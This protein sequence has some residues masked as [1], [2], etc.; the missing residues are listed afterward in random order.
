MAFRDRTPRPGGPNKARPSGEIALA[1]GRGELYLVPVVSPTAIPIIDPP[2]RKGDRARLLVTASSIEGALGAGQEPEVLGVTPRR[3]GSRPRKR[4]RVSRVADP[5]AKITLL[6]AAEEVFSERGVAGAKVE[7]IAKKAGL[8]KGAFYLHFDSKE[9]AL[10]QIVESWLAR[11][12]S[13]FAA[14]NEY[15]DAPDDPDMLLDFCIEREVQLY[16]FLWQ[17][18][19]TMRILRTCQGE[20]D[21]LIDAFKTDMQ[22]RSREWL[23]Q[24]RRDGLIRPEIDVEIA[25]TLMSGAYEEL[26]ARMVRSSQRPPFEKW[27]ELAQETF[28]RAY[29]T[30]E[31]VL[32][33][34]RRNRRVTTGVHELRRG[35][36]SDAGGRSVRVAREG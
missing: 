36:S 15:P 2:V 7:D 10:K 32:A 21:Y 22:R 14:P 20:Y 9:A 11:C 29:G 34:E 13:L 31:L 35:V 5:K 25:A 26:A 23:D 28:V 19:A 8:S 1:L 3:F 4:G 18:R 30:P 27:L 6:R 12:S 16:E 24:W 33:L 17:T